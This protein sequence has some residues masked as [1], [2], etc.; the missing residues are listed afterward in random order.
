MANAN[1]VADKPARELS[2]FWD[3]RQVGTL[4]DADPLTFIYAGAWLD[5]P[6]PIALA[7]TLPLQADPLATPAVHAF[8]ENLLPEGEQRRIA[9]LRFQASSV[10]GLLSSIGGDTA[11]AFTLLPAGQFPQRPTYEKTSWE[12]V[13]R[14]LRPNLDPARED[15]V[16]APAE[17]G[18]YRM[19]ISGAQYKILLSLDE[20]GNPLRPVGAT[21]STLI[22]KP[23]IL[24]S[25]IRLFATAINE[26]IVMR[27]ATLCGMSVAAVHYQPLVKACLVER[28]DRVRQPDG[29]LKRLW[30]ADLCQLAGL[31]SG[32]KY[33]A[34]NGPGFARCYALVRQYSTR[35]AADL[36]ALLQW[37]F[38]NLYVGNN[39]SHAKNLAMLA[40]DHAL[41]LA[42]F[43]DLMSTRVY[44]G[45]GARF[46]FSIG[47]ES[48]PGRIG[49]HQ[50]DSLAAE[51]RVS[52]RYIRDIAADMAARVPQAVTAAVREL[53]PLL[54]HTDRILAERLELRI[55]DI[56]TKTRKRILGSAD[57]AGDDSKRPA[58]AA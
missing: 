39:D 16:E 25:D 32:V 45:L 37:L 7:P 36:K 35:P 24:R 46:A 28:Y 41:R 29:S 22:V 51:I 33:E 27:A 1:N 12:E 17:A 44:A 43:Y 8:F 48:E 58:P 3:A 21:P 14:Q 4:L 20:H 50:V 57:A 11:G 18:K 23:D 38:F 26:T 10:F 52:K 31:P 53:L 19:S 9:S 30:Q 56:V 13:A 15:Q 34:D 42:P 54:D 55:H 2:V 5:S 47:G 49:A 40:S 6:D